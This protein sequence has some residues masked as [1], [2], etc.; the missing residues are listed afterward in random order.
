MVYIQLERWA[1]LALCYWSAGTDLV[2]LTFQL[3][4]DGE[5]VIFFFLVFFLL[6]FL[7]QFLSYFLDVFFASLPSLT[8]SP[9][10]PNPPLLQTRGNDHSFCFRP[11][12]RLF[13]VL[14]LHKKYG[15][16]CGLKV[17]AL[18][19]DISAKCEVRYSKVKKSAENGHFCLFLSK[20]SIKSSWFIA[21]NRYFLPSG[22][23]SERNRLILWKV[24][25]FTFVQ[26]L[27]SFTIF[28]R[29]AECWQEVEHAVTFQLS[30]FGRNNNLRHVFRQRT[31]FYVLKFTLV[32]QNKRKVQELKIWRNNHLWFRYFGNFWNNF[33]WCMAKCFGN[34]WN[35][36]NLMYGE[37]NASEIS[38]TV[39]I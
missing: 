4:L 18:K 35:S 37:A 1:L 2:V 19:C 30:Y 6:F 8:H 17:F 32:I 34:F 5:T 22:S 23:L 33:N 16:F 38:E 31:I 7:C 39:W 3:L 29:V 20:I 13:R 26:K 15:L 14:G 25:F 9:P 10:P 24:V 11:F 28:R 21:F 12:A 27:P 36:F